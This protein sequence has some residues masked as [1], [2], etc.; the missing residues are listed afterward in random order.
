MQHFLCILF[1]M[2]MTAIKMQFKSSFHSIA[3]ID[4]KICCDHAINGILNSIA[5]WDLYWLDSGNK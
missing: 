4:V 5:L 3:E 2:H 1:P